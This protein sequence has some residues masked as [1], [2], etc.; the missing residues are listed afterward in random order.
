MNVKFYQT[1]C[2]SCKKIT[3]FSPTGKEGRTTK[4]RIGEWYV[5]SCEHPILLIHKDGKTE[6]VQL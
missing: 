1:Y 3:L 6:E 5:C 2:R 4:G